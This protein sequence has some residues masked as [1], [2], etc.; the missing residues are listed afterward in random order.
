MSDDTQPMQEIDH[1]HPET[2]V[3][4]GMNYYDSGTVAADGGQKRVAGTMA[5]VDHE[6][7]TAGATRSFERGSEGRDGQV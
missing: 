4:F 3:P 7:P 2:N 5:D 1:T 6:G